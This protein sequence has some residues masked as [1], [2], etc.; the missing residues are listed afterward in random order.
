MTIVMLVS[1]MAIISYLWNEN[2]KLAI[3]CKLMALSSA[4]LMF[5]HNI[6]ITH[7]F[8]F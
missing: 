8:S 5:L 4:L 6:R 2:D 1:N 7:D 3:F